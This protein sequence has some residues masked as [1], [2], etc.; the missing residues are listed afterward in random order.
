VGKRG[1]GCSAVPLPS[2]VPLGGH[3]RL[4]GC[5]VVASQCQHDLDIGWAVSVRG[6]VWLLA[7]GAADWRVCAGVPG[8]AVAN[9]TRVFA[10]GVVLGANGAGVAAGCTALGGVPVLLTFVALSGWAEGDVFGQVAF[11]VEQG[12][13][14]CTK[15]FLGHFTDEGDDH[16]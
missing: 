5:G 14:G 16:G 12:E 10:C 8:F 4:G 3:S 7:V 15:R 9:R 11:A 6:F 1:N 2:V 13:A